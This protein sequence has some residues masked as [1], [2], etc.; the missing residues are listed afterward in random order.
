MLR[1]IASLV[2][3]IALAGCTDDRRPFVE[4]PELPQIASGGGPVLAQPRFVSVTFGGDPLA[5]QLDDFTTRY[6]ASAEWGVLAEY[7]VGPA[8]AGTPI[9]LTETPP[10][11]I[12]DAGIQA[13]LR[14]RLD[15]THSEWGNADP[16]TIYTIY[17][18]AGTTV[19]EN[20]Q[21]T[22]SGG[23]E[24]G[25]YHDET[26]TAAGAP[27]VYAVVPRCDGSIDHITG[28]ASHELAEAATDP[29]LH[30]APAYGRIDPDHL[31]FAI[32]GGEVGDLCEKD[33]DA[34]LRAADVGYVVQRE[35][36]NMAAAADHQPCL[37]APAG[38]V[39]FIS[40]PVVDDPIAVPIGNQTLTTLGVRL[41]V[42]ESKTIHIELFSDGPTSGAWTVSAVDAAMVFGGTPA[43]SFTWD[44]TTGKT[45]D[46]LHL[47]VKAIGPATFMG[48][49]VEP[50]AIVS[51]LGSTR[52]IWLVLATN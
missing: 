45:G 23:A 4:P 20:G 7:G 10:T 5:A 28:P 33:S 31:A 21:P 34:M 26:T 12:D 39:F 25:G 22:C 47:T 41:A 52:R 6:A 42:G 19:S 43:L 8:K 16:S 35:W 49:P 11:S 50:F 15:G 38:D 1:S 2:P 48:A 44:H 17:Y 37:P 29:H 51:Q 14:D 40:A 46:T 32:V 24:I 27:I 9:H 3:L 13:W 30:S 36:S 18:P